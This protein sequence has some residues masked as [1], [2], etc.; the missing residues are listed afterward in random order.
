MNPPKKGKMV[1]E[2]EVPKTIIFYLF[3]TCELSPSEGPEPKPHTPRLE[4]QN[5]NGKYLDSA[6]GRARHRWHVGEVK[7]SFPLRIQTHLQAFC[8]ELQ[9]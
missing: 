2:R 6:L 1:G 8:A 5:N 4:K 3:K 9:R 7:T